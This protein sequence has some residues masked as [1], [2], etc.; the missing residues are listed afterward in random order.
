MTSKEII[1]IIKESAVEIRVDKTLTN[2]E[3]ISALQAINKIYYK[4]KIIKEK[5]DEKER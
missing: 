2:K 5:E 4:I 1:D 3:K